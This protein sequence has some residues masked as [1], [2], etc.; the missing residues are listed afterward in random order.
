MEHLSYF[1]LSKE[2]RSMII[3][4]SS[5][6]RTF[7][8]LHK[9][10]GYIL[11]T[12]P[13]INHTNFTS[14]TDGIKISVSHFYNCSHCDDIR[15]DY[16]IIAPNH[17][18]FAFDHYDRYLRGISKWDWDFTCLFGY[19]PYDYSFV[20]YVN[21]FGQPKFPFVIYK[22]D[23][24]HFRTP[25]SYLLSRAWDFTKTIPPSSTVLISAIQWAVFI[26]CRK[27]IL[28]GCDHDYLQSIHKNETPHFYE[29]NLGH[30]DTPH[31]RNINTEKWFNILAN[32]W[33]CYRNIDLY[34][35]N[36]DIK[37]LNATPNSSLDV[38]E[39]ITI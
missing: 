31:L 10:T 27:I 25:D 12:G 29:A 26:G 22:T 18:P 21:S 9:K 1:K 11:C 38:F 30:D 28:L 4:Y 2:T 5:K 37:I 15:P 6:N 13:S 19:S 33:A 14:L 34:C 20:R 8:N 16:H 24:N 35:K 36:R 23:L 32:R 3:N 7:K 17:Q 39:S